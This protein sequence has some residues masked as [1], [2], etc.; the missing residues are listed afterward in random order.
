MTLVRAEACNEIGEAFKSQT[1]HGDVVS[2]LA[3]V[4]QHY[5]VALVWSAGEGWSYEGGPVDGHF[6]EGV[7][8]PID[9]PELEMFVPTLLLD[10]SSQSEHD[11]YPFWFLFSSKEKRMKLPKGTGIS[12]LV[13]PSQ[14]YPATHVARFQREQYYRLD[15]AVYPAGAQLVGQIP[16]A[17]RLPPNLGVNQLTTYRFTVRSDWILQRSH[18]SSFA[19]EDYDKWA[20]ELFVNIRQKLA[21]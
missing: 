17:Y 8:N 1:N 21:N 2:S 12:L 16:R 10:L 15:L 7:I 9:P 6:E 3:L 5:L 14:E 19:E 20:R 13:E 18:G 11:L 4:L